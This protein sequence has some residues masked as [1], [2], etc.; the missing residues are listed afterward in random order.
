MLIDKV[1]YS[2]E[3]TDDFNNELFLFEMESKGYLTN[4]LLRIK[5]GNSYKLDFYDIVRLKQD[6]ESELLDGLPCFYQE[7]LIIVDS[8]NKKKILNA[9][10]F[11]WK[12]KTFLR[13]VKHT[14]D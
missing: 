13:M 3:I 5:N 1:D 14:E 4:T 6:A 9:I 7:N 12:N 10:E 11:V 2:I 8:L